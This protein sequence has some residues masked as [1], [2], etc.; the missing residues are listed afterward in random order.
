MA[1]AE[2]GKKNKVLFIPDYKMV[3]NYSKMLWYRHI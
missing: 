3:W 1:W 2:L